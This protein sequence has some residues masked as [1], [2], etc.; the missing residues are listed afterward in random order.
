MY[1]SFDERI[2]LARLSEHLLK[3]TLRFV[4]ELIV[5]YLAPK[6]NSGLQI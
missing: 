1:W 6:S 3:G 4:I 2:P 5:K